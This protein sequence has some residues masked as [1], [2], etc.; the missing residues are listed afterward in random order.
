MSWRLSE[1]SRRA[2]V[3]A[4]NFEPSGHGKS[5]T[6]RWPL[7][8]CKIGEELVEG[9]RGTEREETGVRDPISQLWARIIIIIII[10]ITITIAITITIHI[11]VI[12]IITIII[13]TIMAGNSGRG[14]N[15]IFYVSG[16]S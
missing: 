4:L 9:P 7:F 12:C 15:S 2:L 1:D 11:T 14:P 16:R 6:G 8:F 10:I 13:I 3:V 5:E